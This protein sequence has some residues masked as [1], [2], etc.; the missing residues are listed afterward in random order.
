MAIIKLY[1]PDLNNKQLT[2][3]TMQIL[4]Q[5]LFNILL[6]E[7]TV[8]FLVVTTVLALFCLLILLSDISAFI[9]LRYKLNYTLCFH[10]IQVERCRMQLFGCADVSGDP[11]N[12]G[13]SWRDDCSRILRKEVCYSLKTSCVL[14]NN[15]T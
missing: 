11:P 8:G 10:L 4:V 14:L 3:I 15:C 1:L 12:P 9:F 13:P 7:L 5:P 2:Q 6:C